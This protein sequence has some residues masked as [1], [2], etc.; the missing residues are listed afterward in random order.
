M[1]HFQFST[2]NAQNEM[3][4]S[5]NHSIKIFTQTLIE[6]LKPVFP[7]ESYFLSKLKVEIHTDVQYKSYAYV[8]H[9]I[10]IFQRQ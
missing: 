10:E 3:L 2:K 1:L 6:T 9:M 8:Q 5:E 7:K 4:P